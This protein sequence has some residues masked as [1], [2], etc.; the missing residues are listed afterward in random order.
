M[1]GSPDI[2]TILALVDEI[3]NMYLGAKLAKSASP[4]I[5]N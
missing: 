3:N 1:S 4:V 2:A 5:F